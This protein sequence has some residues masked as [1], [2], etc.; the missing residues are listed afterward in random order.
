MLRLET[1]RDELI[2]AAEL[3]RGGALPST[4]TAVETD[5]ST[6]LLVLALEVSLL[7]DMLFAAVGSQYDEA[8]DHH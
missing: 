1:V 5:L 6:E 2:S 7:A 3:L 8:F 4:L